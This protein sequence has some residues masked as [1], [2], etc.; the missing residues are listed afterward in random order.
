MPRLV[1]IRHAKSS[2]DDPRAEDHA[3]VL[4]DRGR[5]AAPRIGRWLAER[6]FVPDE[7]LCSDAVRTR[8]TW[9]LIAGEFEV[10]PEPKLLGGLYLAGRQKMLEVLRQATGE[11]VAMLGHNPGIGDFA[12][13]MAAEAPAHPKFGSYPS[14]AT[15]VLEFEEDWAEVRPGT[16]RVLDF[17]V[18][19]DLAG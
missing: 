2:W 19:K 16:G 5:E 4:N 11:T 10:A 9:Q 17:V 12:G 15:A 7:V 14:A 8:E 3:R 6:G 18:P 1:L 13:W